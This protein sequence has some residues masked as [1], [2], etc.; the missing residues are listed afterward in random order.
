[1]HNGGLPP[2]LSRERFA[3]DHH[4]VQRSVPVMIAKTVKQIA[5][6]RGDRLNGTAY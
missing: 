4:F 2:T 1:M 6:V 5:I 3:T